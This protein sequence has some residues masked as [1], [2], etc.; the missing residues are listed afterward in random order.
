M[1]RTFE[2][3]VEKIR[4]MQEW[5]LEKIQSLGFS[6]KEMH[7]IELALE[8][9][10]INVILH[11][12]SGQ[13]GNIEIEVKILS[14][15]IEIQLIDSSAPFNP[16]ENR[17]LDLEASI[18]ERQIGGLGIHFIKTCMDEV[19]YERKSDQNRLTLVKQLPNRSSQTE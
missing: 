15:S 9:A 13:M 7:K 18:E 14:S 11:G 2:A 16:L 17:E 1:R 10:I 19:R 6:S 5:V 12:L 3:K 4:S 8:E